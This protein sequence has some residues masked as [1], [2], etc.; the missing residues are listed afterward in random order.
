MNTTPTAVPFFFGNH[1]PQQAAMNLE[2]PNFD[3]EVMRSPPFYRQLLRYLELADPDKQ[4]IE[5]KKAALL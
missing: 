3:G 5:D 2:P 4:A 1:L